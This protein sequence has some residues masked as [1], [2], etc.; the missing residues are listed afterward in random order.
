MFIASLTPRIFFQTVPVTV[1]VLVLETCHPVD[2]TIGF[3]NTGPIRIRWIVILALCQK[4][5]LPGQGVHLKT[6]I[7]PIIS[8]GEILKNSETVVM[9]FAQ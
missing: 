5:E 9:L 8:N 6:V 2:N 7:H 4:F 1:E 3:P